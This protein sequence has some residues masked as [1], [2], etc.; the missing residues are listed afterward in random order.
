MV[1]KDALVFSDSK[2]QELDV[3]IQGDK[4]VNIADKL[5]GDDEI[6]MKGSLLLP[7]FIDVHTHGRAGYD[8]STATPEEI[9]KMCVSYA[10]NGVT[11]ILATTMTME[12]HKLKQIMQNN[13]TAIEANYPG[14]RILGINLEGPFLGPDRKGC[15][16]EQYLLPI[17]QPKFE[18]LDTL[19]GGNIRLLDLDPN[20]P[21]AME[22]IK[23]YSKKK[24]ISLAHTSAGYDTA[25]EAVN[26]G[27]THVTHLFNAMNSLHHREPGMIGMVVDYPVNAELICEG[28]HVHPSVIRM[29]FRLIGERIVMISDSMSA[30]GL[31]AGE[32]E[33]GGLKVFVNQRKATLMDGTIA[34]STT[35]LLEEVKNVVSFGL[36]LEDA[37]IA[38]SKNP[39]R[40]IRKEHEVG[41]IK[42]GL[43]ADFL[44]VS[45]EIDLEQVYIGGKRFR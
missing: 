15:H 28:I 41:E 24:T 37:I 35:N 34:G 17:D 6:S 5:Y 16:D 7:G 20:L 39:A 44:V 3:E 26:A 22:F 40:A 43:R 23:E 27:A 30:A 42:V 21:G 18:E 10:E 1:I 13:R 45:K 8:F 31:G 32:Y 11:S 29:M 36:P 12:F 14:S 2:F 19:S 4:I 38:A 9:A 33:L 25:C